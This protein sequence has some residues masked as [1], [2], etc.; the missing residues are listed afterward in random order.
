[1]GEPVI[2]DVV[3]TAFG[4]RGGALANW[5]P[6]DLLGFALTSLVERTGVDPERIDD[7]IGGCVSQVGEQSTNVARNAWVAAGPAPVG[8]GHHR[9]PPVRVLAAGRPLRRGRRGG[10]PLRHGHR[11]RGGVD[12]PRARWPRN[13]RGGT[14]PFPPSFLDADRRAGCGRSSGWPRCWPTQWK[15][16]PPG[17][18]RRTRSRATGARRSHWDSG[19]FAKEAMPVPIRTTTAPSPTSSSST[20]EGIRRD[21]TLERTRRAPP[22]AD[23]GSPTPRPTSRPATRR[24]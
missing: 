16:T 7:V 14:G 17:H 24:R 12:E 6:A 4:K 20:D 11:L 22:R 1:M 3:R 21:T 19:H 2:V 5:H 15:I 23:A 9:G 13:A 10:R 18:G 8:A